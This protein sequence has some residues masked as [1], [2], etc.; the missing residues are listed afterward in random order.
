[1]VYSSYYKLRIL[2]HLYQGQKPYTIYKTIQKEGLQ[3]SRRG[4]SKF[5]EKYV[6]IGKEKW[7]F[8]TYSDNR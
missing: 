1:M 3:T 8:Q 7:L 2:H 5:I 4:V 6:E